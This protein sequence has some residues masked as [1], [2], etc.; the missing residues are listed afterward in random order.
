MF[1]EVAPP[2]DV[3][4]LRLPLIGRV[5]RDVSGAWQ[6]FGPDGNRH[7][8]CDGS[9]LTYQP[10]TARFQLF[11]LTRTTCCAGSAFSAPL[12]S[13]GARPRAARSAIS[14]GG[15]EA[16]Q[17]PSVTAERVRGARQRER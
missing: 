8:L 4:Q 7:R 16:H 11:V 14:F 1:D 15:S 3:F 9:S 5:D 10:P 6:V 2:R 13:S 17:I 12:T